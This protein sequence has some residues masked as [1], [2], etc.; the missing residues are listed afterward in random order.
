VIRWFLLGSLAAAPVVAQQ[1]PAGVQQ[2]S[3][4][5]EAVRLATEGRTD[6]ARSL[7]NRELRNVSPQD[8]R[9]PSILFTAGVIS[10]DPDTARTYFR[11]VSIEYSNSNWADRAIL[12]LAQLAYAAGDKDAAVRSAEQ[13]IRDYPFSPIRAEAAFIAARVLLDQQ[14]DTAG[15]QYLTMTR[16]AAGENVELANRAA[17]YLQRCGLAPAA[18]Q[19]PAQP[20]PAPSSANF[21]VQVAAV[22]NPA[23]ADE[24]MR[25]LRRDGYDAQ[26][27]KEDG[28][29]KV[30]VGRFR[31]RAEAEALARELQTRIGGQPF[32]VEVR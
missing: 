3:L 16:D 27:T 15:C 10:T 8:D 24:L 12:R 23:A 32:V 7:I 14:N 13:V 20:T 22:Q 25:G 21:A 4:L 30:R 6:S 2:D 19:P 9:Y 28:Y 26:V 11:R 1:V 31:R 29:L 18:S 17:F 5:T